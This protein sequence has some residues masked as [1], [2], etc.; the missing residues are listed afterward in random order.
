[1]FI[2]KQWISDYEGPVKETGEEKEWKATAANVVREDADEN[3]V[4]PA[5]VVPPESG[6][7]VL[8]D[9]ASPTE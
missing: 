3:K 7:P 1:M 2:H 6:N 8:E 4:D 5:F 9:P